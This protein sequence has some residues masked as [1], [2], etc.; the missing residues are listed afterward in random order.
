MSPFYTA[1]TS[2]MSLTA[3]TSLITTAT[4]YRMRFSAPVERIRRSKKV[5]AEHVAA[6]RDLLKDAE[7]WAGWL[8]TCMKDACALHN[9]IS[10]GDSV[11]HVRPSDIQVRLFEQVNKSKLDRTSWKLVEGEVSWSG[12]LIKTYCISLAFDK[13]M[14]D[15]K[16]D[17]V[18]KEMGWSAHIFP[19]PVGN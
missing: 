9:R 14:G 3:S 13:F 10:T 1:T 5:R 11:T 17:M 15:H 18:D 2:K 16:V 7:G 4:V 8:D 6:A 19:G 12:P